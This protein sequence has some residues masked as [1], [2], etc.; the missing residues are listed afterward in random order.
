MIQE[1]LGE[2]EA[3]KEEDMENYWLIQYQKLLNTKPQSVLAAES[4]LDHKVFIFVAR[5]MCP[6]LSNPD[7][8]IWNKT[9]DYPDL[10]L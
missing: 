6:V 9:Y 4:K 5:K 1:L 7:L 8:K 10:T 3:G 2:L